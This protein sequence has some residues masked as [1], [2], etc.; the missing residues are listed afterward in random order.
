MSVSSNSQLAL[1]VAAQEWGDWRQTFDEAA[2]EL[3]IRVAEGGGQRPGA[4]R[5]E[6]RRH[7]FAVVADAQN[8]AIG[9]TRARTASAWVTAAAV[10]DRAYFIYH[11]LDAMALSP[12]TSLYLTPIH[13]AC[14]ARE[15][16]AILL[17][18]DSGSGKSSLAYASARRGWT[19]VSD[20]A[21]PLVRRLAE[22]R[23]VVGGSHR[24]RLRPDARALFPELAGFEPALR[25]NGKRSIQIATRELGIA[26]AQTANAGTIVLPRRVAAGAA[27][28]REI[29]KAQVREHCGQW[30]YGWD[31]EVL[32]EQRLAFETLLGGVRTFALE[33]ADLEQAVDA[34]ND[35]AQR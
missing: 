10:E 14:V 18:G 11:F 19:F 8:F 5:F 22:A 15:G 4:T 30:F 29:D 7:L 24:V 12:I 1:D 34:L 6:A 3:T 21:T 27:R 16:R 26:T 20:D 23:T 9:D 17:C 32:A 35:A 31:A 2:V 28:L 25:G 13:G 33:F